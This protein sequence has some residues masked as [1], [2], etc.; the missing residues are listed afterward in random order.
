MIH[1]P[2]EWKALFRLIFL[3]LLWKLTG[4]LLEHY[5]RRSIFP[6]S[7]K[8]LRSTPPQKRIWRAHNQVQVETMG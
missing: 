6:A 1:P 7:T 2:S 8:C 4:D 5:G 3:K